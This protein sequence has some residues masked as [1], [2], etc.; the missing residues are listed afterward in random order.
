MEKKG[1]PE[2]SSEPARRALNAV[3]T[4]VQNLIE[5]LDNMN[6]APSKWLAR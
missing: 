3:Y 1:D 5:V 2:E 4:M 6:M